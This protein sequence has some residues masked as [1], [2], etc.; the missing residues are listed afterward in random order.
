MLTADRHAMAERAIRAFEQQTYRNRMLY[1]L[2]NGV[3]RQPG[4]TWRFTWTKLD[5]IPELKGRP[6]F[7][8]MNEVTERALAAFPDATLV[9]KWDSDDWSHPER[10]SEQ[11]KII[12]PGDYMVTGY[13]SMPLLHDSGEVY[14]YSNP[15]TRYAVGTSLL[16]RRE[17]WEQHH[18]PDTRKLN[19]PEGRRN[20]RGGGSDT[21]WVMHWGAKGQVN[22]VDSTGPDGVPRMVASLHSGNAIMKLDERFKKSERAELVRGLME[23]A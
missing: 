3:E 11:V 14:E 19:A 4:V 22:A 23:N 8:L 17:A 5:Y 7:Q 13:N 10:L 6:L 21:Q 12:Q 20:E 18:F 1:I 15:S 9:A 2:D 16:Y